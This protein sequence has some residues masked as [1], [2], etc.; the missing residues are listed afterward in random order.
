M[1][2]TIDF[3]A[4]SKAVDL[5]VVYF[6]SHCHNFNPTNKTNAILLF[7]DSNGTEEYTPVGPGNMDHELFLTTAQ[8]K[9]SQMHANPTHMSSYQSRDPEKGDWGGG[10]NLQVYGKTALSGL[11]ELADEAC[12]LYGLIHQKMVST[13][14]VNTV[15]C[16]SSNQ[17][18]FE[19]IS[20]GLS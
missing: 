17:K 6:G 3:K 4:L 2:R 15:L 13:I 10:I 19:H 5:A 7:E 9:N 16:A 1:S 20:K 18:L 11:P 8:R 14:F 12:L